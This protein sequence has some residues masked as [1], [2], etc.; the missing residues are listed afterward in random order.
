MLEQK[1]IFFL[2]CDG[3]LALGDRLINGAKDFL[4]LLKDKQ[5]FFYILTNNSSKTPSQHLAKFQRLDLDVKLNNVLVSSQSALEYFAQNE[6]RNIFWLANE[7]VTEFIINSGF[8]YTEDEP[9]ALLLTYDDTINYEKLKKFIALIR[10]GLPYYATHLDIVCPSP[11]GFLPDIGTYIKLIEMTTGQLPLKT[12][13][14]PN[15]S[16]ID[17]ILKKHNL[18]YNDAVIIGDRLYTDIKLAENS[19]ITSVLVLTGETNESDCK[20]SDIK[21][22]L[23]VAN[24]SELRKFL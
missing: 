18:N 8:K 16:F 20:K 17:P 1:K 3:T 9:Q 13:G 5:K 22:D 23:V 14:K 12:F 19:S 21:S 24:L 4:Q 6:I 7:A 15:K 2:D 11:E 10:A